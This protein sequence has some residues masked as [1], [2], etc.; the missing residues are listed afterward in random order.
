MFN[1]LPFIEVALQQRCFPISTNH[2]LIDICS[3]SHQ[4]NN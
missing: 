2:A 4:E 3:V 1:Q